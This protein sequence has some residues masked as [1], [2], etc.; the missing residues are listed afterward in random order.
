M[1]VEIQP[2]ECI[3]SVFFLMNKEIQLLFQSLTI[4]FMDT[5]EIL[6]SLLLDWPSGK[7]LEDHCEGFPVLRMCFLGWLRGQRCLID[8]FAYRNRQHLKTA[9]TFEIYNFWEDLRLKMW[10][11][12]PPSLITWTLVRCC[13]RL[14]CRGVV[15]SYVQWPCLSNLR[16]NKINLVHMILKNSGVPWFSLPC[17]VK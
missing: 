4:S 14:H 12:I 11:L 1:Y 13:E 10:I 17:V 3:H 16:P 8:F 2:H 6:R 7:R 15:F 9:I 5:A